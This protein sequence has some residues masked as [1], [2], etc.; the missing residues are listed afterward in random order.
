MN[1]YIKNNNTSYNRKKPCK[2]DTCTNCGS[3]KHMYK[4]CSEPITSWGIIL[5]AYDYKNNNKPEHS[6]YIVL[7]DQYTKETHT[8]V[9]IETEDDRMVV[10]S[11]Y[12]NIKFLMI[13]RKHSVGYVEFIRGRYRSE[14]ID[15][16]IYLFRQ[17][18]QS[19]IY[20]IK[21]SLTIE[22]GFDYLWQDFWGVNFESMYIKD[23]I[24]SKACYD[25]LK[26]SGVEGPE[27]DLKYIATTVKAD[28][29]NE[30][31]GFPKG[32]KNRA[33][34]EEECAVREFKEESG[35]SDDDFRV[36]K[37]IAPMTEEFIG[38]NGIRYRHVYYIA[39]LISNKQPI[40]NITESQKNEIGNIQF[41][42]FITAREIIRD[43]HI[44]R[45]SIIET[46]FL[47]Y[48]DHLVVANRL[49]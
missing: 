21:Y 6:K 7:N 44:P 49:Q 45:K 25:M 1:I 8:R 27:I 13:S 32:R 28:Y 37:N 16:I 3:V 14:K 36:I 33:E 12:H 30:E 4:Q 34:T 23:K 2:Y 35:Y 38:T 48:L 15:Q 17:M 39:E 41:M 24:K 18:M 42:D 47:Y 19:E 22:G 40:N 43:Y 11:A 10:S 20:K 46:L 31:W 29:D 26:M 9:S 5:V